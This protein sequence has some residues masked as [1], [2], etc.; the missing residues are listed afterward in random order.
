MSVSESGVTK[1]INKQNSLQVLSVILLLL[2]PELGTYFPSHNLSSR[3]H[4]ISW[5]WLENFTGGNTF[6]QKLV[7]RETSIL[8]T[9][10]TC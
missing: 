4:Y 8:C 7:Y 2:L 6:V 9:Y 10:L 1:G 3:E 5:V